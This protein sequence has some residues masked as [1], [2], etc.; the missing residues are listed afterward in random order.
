MLDTLAETSSETTDDT[1]NDAWRAVGSDL[2]SSHSSLLLAVSGGPDSLAMLIGLAKLRDARL[3]ASK[4][5][6][7][8][9]DHGL[10]PEA[11]E[12]AKMVGEVCA[13][14]DVPF[15]VTKLDRKP[16]A[17][18]AQDW[19][20]TE[21]Y[22]ALSRTAKETQSVILTAHTADD[23]AETLLM[24]AA[25]GTGCEGLASIR[26][27][28]HLQGALVVRPFLDWPRAELHRVL[29]GTPWQPT[30]DPSNADES[31]TRV[32]FRNWLADA[33]A[34]DGARGIVDG[35]AETAQIAGLENAA[36][37]HYAHQLF[38]EVG[39]ATH[40]FVD[41]DAAL[42]VQPLVVQARFLRMALGAV[43][44]IRASSTTDRNLAFGLGRMV[45]LARRIANEPK[46]KWVGGG[47]VLEWQSGQAQDG[48]RLEHLSAYAEAGRAGFP[49]L[50][51]DPGESCQWD[52]RFEV[53]NW[54]KERL[55]IR[56]WQSKDPKPALGRDGLSTSI[57]ASLPV[58]ARDGEVIA[59][60]GGPSKDACREAGT[61]FIG[62]LQPESEA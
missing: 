20:R 17:R 25:R 62:A 39:G 11:A 45:A 31:Y 48:D 14:L 44:R 55:T 50:D 56:A 33:P 36:L 22:G 3:L 26:A 34:P 46:G 58:A 43:A 2:S 18:N 19:A 51:V 1:I 54:T 40:G 13:E 7:Q 12:E 29:H 6:V 16:F 53:C 27:Q 24:R 23:Q 38:E 52:D 4:L 57:L 61:A 15:K 10:R 5:S 9:I 47:A 59:A 30:Q 42:C 35:L 21:R 28:T 37:D 8:T 32:R 60:V 41:G 49:Q